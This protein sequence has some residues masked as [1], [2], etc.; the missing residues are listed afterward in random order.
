MSR[1]RLPTGIRNTGYVKGMVK[2]RFRIAFPSSIH[3]VTGLTSFTLMCLIRVPDY[4]DPFF[5]FPDSDF[6]FGHVDH[7]SLYFFNADGLASSL[8][9]MEKG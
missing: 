3:K 2:F 4:P 6:L 5:F 8:V 7:V 1:V 9:R